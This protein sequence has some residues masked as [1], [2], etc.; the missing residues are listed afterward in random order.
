[1]HFSFTR[2]TCYHNVH[3]GG[4]VT[5]LCWT[6]CDPM[7]CSLPCSS[8][9]RIPRQEH[10]SG[11]PFPSP[12]IMYECGQN[13]LEKHPTI[14]W[15]KDEPPALHSDKYT[16]QKTDTSEYMG[17]CIWAMWGSHRTLSCVTQILLCV[18][19]KNWGPQGRVFSPYP[20]TLLKECHVK[21]GLKGCIYQKVSCHHTP[22]V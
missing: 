5:K 15:L 16:A 2:L 17:H 22:P 1:M 18:L 10:W 12:T 6:L 7:G 3:G 14:C 21:P 11:L 19:T 4:L 13:F 8:V 20:V 9:H